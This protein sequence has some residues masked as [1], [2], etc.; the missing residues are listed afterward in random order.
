M[1]IEWS[2][3]LPLLA[4]LVLTVLVTGPGLWSDAWGWWWVK[5]TEPPGRDRRET[6]R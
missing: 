4:V 3:A 2:L 5:K 1:D 6:R